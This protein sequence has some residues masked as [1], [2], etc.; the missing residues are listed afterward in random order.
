MKKIKK[1][2]IIATI[3]LG[4][5]SCKKFDTLLDNPNLPSPTSADVDLYLNQV[6]LSAASLFDQAEGLTAPLV[7]MYVYY[8]PT[9]SN[10]YSPQSF[11]GIWGTAYEGVLKNANAMIPVAKGQAKYFHAG[12]A[13]V[14]KAYT[15]F[16]LVDLF[17]DVPYSEA[18]LGVANQ[19]PKADPGASVYKAALDLLDTAILDL[20]KTSVTP[21][22]ILF[23]PSSKAGWI[24]VANTLKLRAYVN[25]R[26]VDP[27]VG[28][29]I[30][31]LVTA[32]NLITATA[33]E[34]TFKYGTKQSTPNSRSSR[35]NGNYV[36]SGGAG[37]Y[38]GIYF[39]Y[40]LFSEKGI[41]DPRIRYYFYRQKTSSPGNVQEEPC[42]FQ[43]R[44]AHY[45]ATDPFCDFGNGVGYW[46]R[47]HGDPTG[48]PPDGN[49]R[50]VPG[51]YPAGG[52][53]D[54]SEG[55][56]TTLNVGGQGAGITP[57]WMSFF[58]DFTLAEAA[59]TTTGYTGD[60]RALLLS[61]VTKSINR[62]MAFPAEIGTS[63]C[64]ARTPDT[65]AV[66]AYI[67]YV[68]AQYDAAATTPLKLDVV[69]KEYYLAL[70]GNGLDA[71]NMYRRTSRPRGLQP[72]ILPGPGAFIRSFLY[73]SDYVNLNTNATQKANWAQKVFWDTNP[74]P[75]F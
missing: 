28:A 56:A 69:L 11:D 36:A 75:L 61:G 50:T 42:A 19:D 9:Y 53:F 1:Y 13:E 71:F 14:L 20:N 49:L 40:A 38:V 45:A 23:S 25:T 62:V 48:I 15:L 70:W 26:L 6:Q 21:V 68:M 46:G 3:T 7:R 10:G 58:T 54:C 2:L 51:V 72:T 35:Y 39:M 18:N 31:T 12:I 32:G 24:K 44:P 66:T 63:A 57:I 65:A 22:N 4:A 17:G 47:N 8:G 64:A 59:L 34:F 33:D 5:F 37:D 74:D 16:T 73:P 52:K 55:T 29:K 43:S 27:S 67:N 60:A 41:I 30:Q